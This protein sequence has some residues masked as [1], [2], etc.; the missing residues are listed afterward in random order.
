MSDDEPG[1]D[2]A[3]SLRTPDD[4]RRLY[5]E[6]ADTYDTEFIEANGYVYH[7]NV[8]DLYVGAGGS[9]NGRTLDVGCGTG[10]VGV[11]LAQQAGGRIDGVDISPEMLAVAEAKEVYD[12][13]IV[14]DLTV[15]L[16][17]PDD[18]YGGVVSVGTFTH[19]HLGAEPIDELLRVATPGALFAIG[20]NRD[21]FAG[22]GF[23]DWFRDR[24]AAGAISDYREHEVTIYEAME[25]EHAS[26]R[27][28]VALFR[29]GSRPGESLS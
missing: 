1:L 10:V 28:T 19:G 7:H 17:Q 24:S 13:L 3:Y 2:A 6:W 14:A 29:A 27:S 23:G 5:A 15:G 18:V 20:V 26:D 9:A 22:L 16:N 8:V 12:S 25:G 4:S 21:H 11:V